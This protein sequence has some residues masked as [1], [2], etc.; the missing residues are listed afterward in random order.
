MSISLAIGD[1]PTDLQ[2]LHTNYN[3]RARVP[4]ASSQLAEWAARSATTRAIYAE[5]QRCMLD[6]A[7]GV[8]AGETL[9]LFVPKPSRKKGLKPVVVFIHG[10]Y[11]RS[12]DKADHSFLVPALEQSAGNK[13]AVVVVPN[14]SLCPS[15]QVDDIAL[16]MTRAMAWVFEHIHTVGG[17]ASQVCVVGHSAGGHLA[18]M[19][20]GCHWAQVHTSAGQPLPENWLRRVV[21]ISGLYDLA[22]LVP[23]PFLQGDLRL[24]PQTVQRCSPAYWPQPATGKLYAVVGGDES[25]EFLRHNDMMRQAWGKK[26]VPHTSVLA[27]LNHFTIVEALAAGQPALTRILK[28]AL[29]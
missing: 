7:Y 5:Q 9:D 27:G 13:G 12:L 14:Y 10:G 23:A 28:Q 24:S 18:A 16:Q 21:C 8:S 29:Q 19:L 22:P 1:A 15:V 17:D 26:R 6:V 20:L 2:W 4:T 3:N 11:W 25:D